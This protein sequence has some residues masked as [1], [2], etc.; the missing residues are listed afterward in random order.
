MS[1]GGSW[2]PV[3]FILRQSLTSYKQYKPVYYLLGG[4]PPSNE[5]YC[6]NLGKRETEIKSTV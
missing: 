1:G 4:K 6:L 3:I 2:S 5:G